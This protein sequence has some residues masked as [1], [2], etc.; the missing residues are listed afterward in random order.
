MMKELK[1]TYTSILLTNKKCLVKLG[2]IE[3]KS[4]TENWRSFKRPLVFLFNMPNLKYSI[5]YISKKCLVKLGLRV[6]PREHQAVLPHAISPISLKPCQFKGFT[7]KLKKT[8]WFPFWFFSGGGGNRPPP[9]FHGFHQGN[10]VKIC[11]INEALIAMVFNR[12]HWEF[13]YML[14]HP[15][16][17]PTQVSVNLIDGLSINGGK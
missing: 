7:P 4:E 14:L 15:S 11:K 5:N 9:D 1:T 8:N 6:C 16:K 3:W 17:Y 12:L 10:R 2:S 13:V